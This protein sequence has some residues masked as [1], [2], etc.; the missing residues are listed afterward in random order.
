V[1]KA[2]QGLHVT[3]TQQGKLLKRSNALQCRIDGWVKIQELYMPNIAGIRLADKATSADTTFVTTPETFKLWLP[4]QIGRLALCDERLQRIEWRL[5]Y[6]QCHDT[7][8]SVRSSLR[9][10]TAV[11]KY[12]DRNLRG[13]GA[14]TRARSMLKTIDARIEAATGRYEGAHKALVTLGGLLNE[15]GWQLSLR[16]LNHEDIRSMSDVLWGESEGRQ[17]LLWIWNM[18]GTGGSEKDNSGA[19]EGM[20]D[21]IK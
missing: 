9:A 19:L 8:C 3:D 12:K 17:K 6:A 10:Q 2:G 1:D 15:S 7:L 21:T 14:N 11:L 13:Q 18:C 20:H 16:P 5:R 4:S